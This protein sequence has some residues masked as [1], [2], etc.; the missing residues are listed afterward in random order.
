[1]TLTESDKSFARKALERGWMTIDQVDKCRAIAESNGRPLR[2]IAETYGYVRPASTNRPWL[3]LLAFLAA[4]ALLSGVGSAALYLRSWRADKEKALEAARERLRAEASRPPAPSADPVAAHAEA[5][6][7]LR[8]AR[9]TMRFVEDNYRDLPPHER[10]TRLD[11]ALD[12][13]NA[14]LKVF[15]ESAP[16]LFDRARVFEMLGKLREA[17]TDYEAAARD[18]HHAKLGASRIRELRDVLGD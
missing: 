4:T 1:M 10:T 5:E 12:D 15:P 6:G 3:A 2:E 18:P 17:L 7:R 9:D 14:Y 11:Q 16:A 13:L 8:I